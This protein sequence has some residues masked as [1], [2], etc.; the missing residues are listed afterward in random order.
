MLLGASGSGKSALALQLMALGAGLVSDDRTILSVQKGALIASVPDS[1]AGRIEARG[2]GILAAEQ[3]PPTP[4]ALA[5]DLDWQETARLPERHE[6]EL[7]GQSVLLLGAVAAPH[8]PA[9]ILQM[10]ARERSAP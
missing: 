10:L 7:M 4:V 1:I 3:H 6:I 9:A 8:F 2:I 5:V